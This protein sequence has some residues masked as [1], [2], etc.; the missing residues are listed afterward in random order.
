[1]PEHEHAPGVLIEDDQNRSAPNELPGGEEAESQSEPEAW[2]IPFSI[3][4]ADEHGE[5]HVISVPLIDLFWN[6]AEVENLAYAVAD[7]IG[8][9]NPI[10]NPASLSPH[11][12]RLLV[13]DPR[14]EELVEYL[15]LYC[16]G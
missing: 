8:D 12:R 11:F 7:A 13:A 10:G 16:Q 6:S 15:D 1:M 14:M 4:F 3:T 2:Q 5:Q 9:D